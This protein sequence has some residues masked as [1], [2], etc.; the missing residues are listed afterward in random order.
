MIYHTSI[1]NI[2]VRG[3]IKMIKNTNEVL[4]KKISDTEAILRE[5]MEQMVEQEKEGSLTINTVEQLLGCAISQFT[6]IALG[7]SGELLSNLE[8]EKKR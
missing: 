7:M 4:A 1:E 8:V 3:I 5:L 6:K 2:F